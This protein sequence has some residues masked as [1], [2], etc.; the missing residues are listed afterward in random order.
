MRLAQDGRILD[1]NA[2][3]LAA[4]GG[5]TSRAVVGSSIYGYVPA[6]HRE[7]MRSLIS[8]ARPGSATTDV[9]FD[10]VPPD[11]GRRC[12]MKARTAQL[13]QGEGDPAVLCIFDEVAERQGRGP[14]PAAREA[15][16]TTPHGDRQLE[17]ELVSARAHADLVQ[18]EYAAARQDWLGARERLQTAA[19]AAAANKEELLDMITHGAEKIINSTGEWVIFLS[20][21]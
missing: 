20:V 7:T 1:V 14:Q 13:T 11:G 6:E 12:A 3:G 5:A 10:I 4:F 21:L 15:E 19:V 2:A 17:R 16:V 8:N 18:R 9:E